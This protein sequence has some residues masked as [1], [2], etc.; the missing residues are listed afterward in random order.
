MARGAIKG[1]YFLPEAKAPIKPTSS[2]I[3][4]AETGIIPLEPGK[5][6]LSLDVVTP[7]P[8]KPTWF[9][10]EIR[11]PYAKVGES[12][13]FG[14]EARMRWT[15]LGERRLIYGIKGA[16]KQPKIMVTTDG[17]GYHPTYPTGI[18]A[19]EA[20]APGY[21]RGFTAPK[22]IPPD[23][24][25]KT[26]FA[27][28]SIFYDYGHLMR[29]T[30]VKP[31]E[32]P[33]IKPVD[34]G[35]GAV[36][37][38]VKSEGIAP[39]SELKPKAPIEAVRVQYAEP[40]VCIGGVCYRDVG[41]PALQRDLSVKQP[42]KPGVKYAEPFKPDPAFKRLWDEV[43][44]VD[45]RKP[46]A[47]GAEPHRRRKPGERRKTRWELHKPLSSETGDVTAPFAEITPIHI[48]KEDDW[49]KTMPAHLTE[50]EIITDTV[51]EP[52][53]Y[54]ETY[55]YPTPTPYPEPE[56]E[57]VPEPTPEPWGEWTI[58]PPPTPTPFPEPRIP[59]GKPTKDD[60]KRRRK[61]RG[62]RGEYEWHI[63]NPL[64]TLDEFFANPPKPKKPVKPQDMIPM[65]PAG[66]V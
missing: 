47:E 65:I 36:T 54:P 43:E 23:M 6:P 13:L 2:E 10:G 58:M 9:Y 60:L 52:Y 21:F 3:T 5:F 32:T 27:D 50:V 48:S 25:F 31:V 11:R 30:R 14:S 49:R 64:I 22:Q 66:V 45:S 26:T 56:P 44:K 12:Q 28:S 62:K 15:E 8:L 35:I 1:G 39:I 57:E 63:E 40:T 38:R 18:V 51:V 7:K 34:R 37:P 20:V 53:P 59:K 16:P 19:G 4:T 24:Y 55:P 33:P 61:V 42:A 46:T 29:P 17:G 41:M